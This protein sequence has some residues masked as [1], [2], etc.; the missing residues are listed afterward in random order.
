MLKKR[1][2]KIVL[3]S[4]SLAGAAAVRVTLTLTPKNKKK[5]FKAFV[6]CNSLVWLSGA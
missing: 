2:L 5:D 1:Q 4:Q 6:S 3:V